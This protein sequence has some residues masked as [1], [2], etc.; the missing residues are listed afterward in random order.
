MRLQS[1][2][3]AAEAAGYAMAVPEEMI[4]AEE[5]ELAEFAARNKMILSSEPNDIPTGT[6]AA[7]RRM[8]AD[9][10]SWMPVWLQSRRGNAP[11]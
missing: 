6:T 9:R 1:L 3:N 11:A 8:I 2:M 7:L 5:R 10:G 4:V